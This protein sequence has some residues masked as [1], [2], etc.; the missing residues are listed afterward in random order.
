MQFCSARRN[1]GRG[2][3]PSRSA[4]DVPWPFPATSWRR[5]ENGS[6]EA[7][8]QARSE[9][10]PTTHAPGTGVTGAG[11][12]L[13]GNRTTASDSSLE[14]SAGHSFR[15]GVAAGAA[16]PDASEAVAGR[17]AWTS[18][19]DGERGPVGRERGG[20]SLGRAAR[21]R[22]SS[23]RLDRGRGTRPSRSTNDV[24]CPF[25]W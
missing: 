20:S 13:A 8:R 17:L 22:R 6:A 12:R 16:L 2:T 9:G 3:R 14:G 25:F 5:S 19:H 18:V 21:G 4:N 7:P 15:A 10:E 24:P 11:A 23:A 1:R